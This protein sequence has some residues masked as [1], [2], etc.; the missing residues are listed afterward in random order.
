MEGLRVINKKYKQ[1]MLVQGLG[2]MLHT[3]FTHLQKVKDFRDAISYDKVKLATFIAAMHDEGIR[4]IGRGLW[5]ISAVHTDEDI[6][7]ALSIA[8]KIMAKQAPIEQKV[9]V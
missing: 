5:Y 6:S 1:N 8:E 3:G 4:I 2:P 9:S 7:Y